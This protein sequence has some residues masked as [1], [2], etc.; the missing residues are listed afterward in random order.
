M[1]VFPSLTF[2]SLFLVFPKIS[3]YKLVFNSFELSFCTHNLASLSIDHFLILVHEH[4]N[5]VLIQ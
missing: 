5:N 3:K 1:M 2:L 4:V